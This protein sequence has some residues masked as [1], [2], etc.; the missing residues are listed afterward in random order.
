VQAAIDSEQDPVDAGREPRNPA[1]R[2]QLDE[3]K[4]RRQQADQQPERD[5]QRNDGACAPEDGKRR[6]QRQ[7]KALK[8]S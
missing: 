3:R 2:G 4:E 8:K 6:P 7:K 1:G 5:R